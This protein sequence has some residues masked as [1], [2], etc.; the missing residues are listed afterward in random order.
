[1][2]LVLSDL[3]ADVILGTFFVATAVQDLHLKLFV[4]DVTP[5][6]TGADVI[7]DY[8][9]AV[10]G[11]YAQKDLARGAG[12]TLTPADDPSDVIYTQQT[13]TFTGELTTNTTIY[14]YYVTNAA[15]SVLLW[16]EKLPV[17]F[18]PYNNGDQLLITPKLQLSHGTPD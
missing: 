2:A 12:W 6:A 15:E 11:N 4:T 7:G 5:S 17:A 8:T 16:A 9:E 14:G 1:M 3:G 10:G 18:H 13:F